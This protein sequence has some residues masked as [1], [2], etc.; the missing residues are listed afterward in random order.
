MCAEKGMELKMKKVLI[1]FLCFIL[2]C[3]VL[4]AICT[5]QVKTVDGTVS[6]EK[7][8]E[9]ISKENSETK[10]DGNNNENDGKDND[11]NSGENNNGNNNE[12]NQTGNEVSNAEGNTEIND[13]NEGTKNENSNYEYPKY[14]TIK[15][16]H[17]SSGEIE[18]KNIDEYITEVVSAE[19][20]A[21]YE[22]EALKAQA[23][24]ARTY[25]IYQIL[26]NKKH[27]NADICDN[28]ACCQA[29]ISKEDRFAK[30]EDNVREENWNKITNA[31]NET[32][33]K[34][35]TYNES[36]I[37]AFFHSN[38]GGKTE[39]SVNIWG[40]VSYPYLQSVETAGEDGYDQYS[41]SVTLTEEEL[42]KKLKNKYSKIEIDFSNSESIK[43]NEY[44]DSG[45][46]KNVKFGNTEI[47]GTEVRTIL[48]LRSTNFEIKRENDK[49][50]FSVTGYGHGVGMSQ[51]G[52]DS[53][54]KSGSNHEEIIKHFYTGV[55]I[56]YIK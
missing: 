13:N 35:V 28:Y 9:E 26:N 2:I 21:T 53:M 34:I 39:S 24:V 3:F 50:T 51:T 29:W 31:V 17:A 52:A 8:K 25:L 15:L 38:S 5:T 6:K 46:V 20:P 7:D 55:E 54:A 33:G 49:I 40:G 11:G 32:K 1:Y 19:M 43:I 36:P 56:S 18:E 22:I 23:I 12:K 27:E 14:G 16:L 47:A 42:L 45:R 48:G 10:A 4:P 30:W 41:S 44:T 37:N